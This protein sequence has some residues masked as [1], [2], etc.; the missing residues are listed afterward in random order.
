MKALRNIDSAGFTFIEVLLAITLFVIA[1]IVAVDLIRGSVRATQDLKD[2]TTATWLLKKTITE[3]ESKLEAEGFDKACD[4]K[5]EGKFDAPFEKFT[6]VTN[7]NEIDFKLSQ[8]AAALAGGDAE[9]GDEKST[10]QDQILKMILSIASTHISKSMREIHAEVKWVQGKKN[11][12]M[13]DV[14]THLARYDLPLMLPGVSQG[15][16]GGGAQ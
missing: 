6:W 7:C 3:L 11:N 14:T 13:V 5:K 2:V 4:K 15:Q 8:N 16:P 10:Q 12:R 9:S 1:A